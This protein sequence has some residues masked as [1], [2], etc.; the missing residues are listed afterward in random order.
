MKA[1]RTNTFI[2][3]SFTLLS[4]TSAALVLPTNLTSGWTYTGC[5]TDSIG[6]RSLGNAFSQNGQMTGETCVAFCNSRGYAVA[7]TEY[8]TEC[9]EQNSFHQTTWAAKLL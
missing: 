3:S 7:G 1:T 9:C 8:Y 4:L 6:S 2:Y 5:Y